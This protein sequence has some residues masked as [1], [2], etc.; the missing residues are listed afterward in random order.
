MKKTITAISL[1][2]LLTFLSIFGTSFTLRN[3]AA[4]FQ[5][6]SKLGQRKVNFKAD[7]DEISGHWDGI[8]AALQ[9]KVRGGSISMQKMD[10]H[11]R[12]GQTQ[13][14]ELRNNFTDGSVSRVIDLPGNRRFIDKVV[15][16]YEATNTN[17][18][19]KPIVELWGRH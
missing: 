7:R 11:F 2:L 13:E 16:W 1:V 18:G 3:N 5:S 17:T 8:F 15:F 14:I 4:Y 6:W 9:I 10:I 19:G 12:N